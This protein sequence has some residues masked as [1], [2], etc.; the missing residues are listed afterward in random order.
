MA[1]MRQ[2]GHSVL[3]D[4]ELAFP[5]MDKGAWLVRAGQSNAHVPRQR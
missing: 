3:L 2:S 5:V 1:V 4:N